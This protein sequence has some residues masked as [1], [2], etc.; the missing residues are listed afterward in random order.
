MRCNSTMKMHNDLRD[1]MNTFDKNILIYSDNICKN[2][3]T[4]N[5]NLR[6]LLSQNILNN[7]RH[8][9]EAMTQRIYSDVTTITLNSYPD[10]VASLNYVASRGELRFL[11]QFH[12][13]LQTSVSHFTPDEDNSIRL[14]LKYH[15]WLIRIKDYAK[16]TFGLMILGKV[17]DY[18]WDKDDSLDEYYEKIAEAID[19]CHHINANPYNRYYIHKSKPFFQDGK[20]YYELTITS[21]DDYSSNVFR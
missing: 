21:A 11:F 18:P 14:M 10:I 4:T 15:E 17:E 9:V 20:I 8:L 1:T 5:A 12:E 2:I 3:A 13:M 6:G 16:R 19:R 7:L